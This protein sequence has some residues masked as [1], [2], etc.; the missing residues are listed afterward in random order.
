MI[1]PKQLCWSKGE[2]SQ[3][4]ASL[5]E[6]LAEE[7]PIIEGGSGVKLNFVEIA[8]SGAV[9]VQQAADGVTIEYGSLTAAARGIGS[10]MSGVFGEEL[11]TYDTFGIMLDASRN[12]VMTVEHFKKWLR[13]LALLGY[14]MAMLYTED[15][16]KL[17]NEPYFGYMRGAYSLAEMQEVD[18]YAST[19]GIEMIACI[20]TLGHLEQII[21]W[22]PAYATETDT[23]RV[24][25]VG[26][27][28][29]YELVGKMI[30][31]WRQAFRSNRIHIGMD[32]THDLGRG[33]F[34]DKFGYVDG[35]TLF[36]R[37]L[38]RVNDMCKERGLDPM[39]WSD[40]YFRLGN[41]DQNYYD[42]N[43]NIPQEVRDNIP[44]NVELVYWDYYHSDYQFYHDFIKL[45]QELNRPVALGSGVWTWSKF[46]YDHHKTKTTVLPG[47][48][49]CRDTGVKSVFFTM[50]GDD[51]AFCAWD[52]ALAGLTFAGE[53]AYGHGEDESNCTPRFGAICG[54]DYEAHTLAGGLDIHDHEATKVDPEVTALCA[55]HLLWDDPIMG[56][57][58]NYYSVWNADFDQ[59]V[60]KTYQQICDGLATKRDGDG[61]A[62]LNH[63]YLIATTIMKKLI[64]RR[65]LLEVYKSK[66][67]EALVQLSTDITNI[68]T[69]FEML[70]DSFRTVWNSTFKP[71]GFET[72]QIRNAGQIARWKELQRKLLDYS[73]GILPQ[74]EELEQELPLGAPASKP[75]WYKGFAVGS[76]IL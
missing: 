70:S 72:L 52:S 60:L 51:G 40:M 9:N 50:W 49:A 19:L 7:Y 42:L 69:S 24:L 13:R 74:I 35:F 66:D 38:N 65:R 47:L 34:L 33:K 57:A 54:G 39:I 6:L 68:I 58:W 2:V 41:V 26:E 62:D 76:S 22:I 27:D 10:A 17:P 45:H 53:V 28:A 46:W 29:T 64:F 31:F 14:N 16:Y 25:N 44:E 75:P 8:T 11:M 12:G 20:Q 48:Q 63:P 55:Y 21:K 61:C 23:A 30:D 67:K 71:F 15:T 56:L 1:S 43:S 36:N 4:L 32:E 73:S 3:E 37:H 5:L 18:A 59:V